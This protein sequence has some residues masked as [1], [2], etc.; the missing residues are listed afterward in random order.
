MLPP[1][2]ALTF[3][4]ARR[5]RL[6]RGFHFEDIGVCSQATRLLPCV[7]AARQ[8]ANFAQRAPTTF[9]LGAEDVRPLRLTTGGGAD[10]VSMLHVLATA[11][12]QAGILQELRCLGAG[13]RV[14]M[15]GHQIEQ[16]I[17]AVLP[18]AGGQETLH[19][20]ARGVVTIERAQRELE[21]GI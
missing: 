2:G 20:L 6:D 7:P 16:Q 17:G 1:L 19:A 4:L 12:A 14:P 21:D 11:L 10:V 9:L 3:A 13:A 15:L 18:H 8:L 5:A